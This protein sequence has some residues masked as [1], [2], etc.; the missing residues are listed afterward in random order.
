MQQETI[1]LVLV[2]DSVE[3]HL[4]LPD[5][6]GLGSTDDSLWGQL[7]N[8]ETLNNQQPLFR[9]LSKER[10]IEMSKRGL[11]LFNDFPTDTDLVEHDIDILDANI[12][13]SVAK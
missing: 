8:S 6:D 13:W 1:R 12:G 2:V 11:S 5:N 4:S 9:L 3:K 7:K 10:G